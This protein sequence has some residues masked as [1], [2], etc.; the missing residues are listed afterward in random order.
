MGESETRLLNHLDRPVTL[1]G[2]DLTE[3]VIFFGCFIFGV[4]QGA[5]M[6][7]FF[8]GMG[9]A[10]LIRRLKKLNNGTSLAAL[11]YWH[12]PSQLMP[13]KV[14]VPSHVREWVA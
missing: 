14:K 7:G 3:V 10:L 9:L 1:G 5:L 12:L 13:L 4:I 2:I 6:M 11:A 8:A